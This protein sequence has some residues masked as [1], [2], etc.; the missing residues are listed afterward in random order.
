MI[1]SILLSTCLIIPSYKFLFNTFFF[2]NIFI[3]QKKHFLTKKVFLLVI[4]LL[5]KKV[6]RLS[7]ESQLGQ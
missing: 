6:K 1:L 5:F 2:Q 3:V 7:E 4:I